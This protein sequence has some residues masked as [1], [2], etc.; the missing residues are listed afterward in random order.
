MAIN[1][2][3]GTSL[4]IKDGTTIIISSSLTTIEGI[5]FRDSITFENAI[6]TYNC[7]NGTHHALDTEGSITIK[8]GTCNI[9]SGSGKGI[10]D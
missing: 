3:E 8:K 7:E 10:Q 2:T 4:T 1:G 5:Y 9:I 6:Y